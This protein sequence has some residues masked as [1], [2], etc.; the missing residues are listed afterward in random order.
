MQ[1]TTSEVGHSI[2]SGK[3]PF[4][5]RR[6]V[7]G[8]TFTEAADAVAS[9]N[10]EGIQLSLDILGENV[11][12]ENEAKAAGRDY[13]E[14]VKSIVARQLKSH[15]SIK[16]TMLGLD[17]SESLTERLLSDLLTAAKQAGI[18]VRI[19]M[20]GTPYTERTVAMYLKMR[21]QFDNVGIV[22]QAYLHRTA[23][24]LNR[25]IDAGGRVRLCKGAYKEP[26]TH[27]IQNMAE[28]RTNYMKLARLLMTKGNYPAFATHDDHLIKSVLALSQ[29]VGRDKKEFEMQMLYGLRR[30]TWL[31]LVRQGYNMRV[32]VPYGSSWYP[33]FSRRL[34]ERKENVF[35]ILRNLFKS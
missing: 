35:F 29:E 30:Q 8:L 6:F 13:I 18:F 26:A 9:L 10:S 3:I 7:A 2:K 12:D 31:D 22:L 11:K 4:Y 5:A 21:Q 25:V 17:I 1:A 27:A 19:D 15:I 34:R 28:I 33:Y 23:E 16:L 20:E 14:L 24:D 32:Y